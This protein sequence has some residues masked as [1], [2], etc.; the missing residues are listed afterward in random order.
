MATFKEFQA[1]LTAATQRKA[2]LNH[3]IEHIDANFRPVAGGEP[4]KILMLDDQSPVP[5]SAFEGVVVDLLL[6]TTQE[7]DQ[8]IE[9]ILT[10]AMTPE[11]TA[12]DS[13]A[14]KTKNGEG[15]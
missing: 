12:V 1:K 10:S 4:K 6:K 9:K 11:V 3:L 2:V 13:K 5:A 7:L 14:K 15:K 8:E